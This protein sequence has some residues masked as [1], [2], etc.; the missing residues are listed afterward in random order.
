M[1]S[2]HTHLQEFFTK[3]IC[4]VL[5]EGLSMF[6]RGPVPALINF[7]QIKEDNAFHQQ[8]VDGIKY[9]GLYQV[10]YK[11]CEYQLFRQHTSVCIMTCII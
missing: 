4:N 11:E 8:L 6:Q 3:F 1:Y 10:S 5:I 9:T 7:D 2:D